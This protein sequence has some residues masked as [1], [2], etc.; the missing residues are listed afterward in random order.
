MSYILNA[1]K[2]AERDR[3]RED[4]QDLND[5]ASAHWDPYQSPPKA[6]GPGRW[7]VAGV[8]LLLG[9]VV[10]GFLSGQ[11][12]QYVP[13]N[14]TT[15]ATP[16]ISEFVPEV[17]ET[18]VTQNEIRA[19]GTA[20]ISEAH[21][22]APTAETIPDFRVA[23]HMFINEGSSSNRLFIGDR[24]LREGDA[25]DKT[26]TLVSINPDNFVIRDGNRT[27]ILSYR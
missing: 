27:E 12:M 1:L 3:L 23:G 15:I 20:N 16:L 5:F 26:W 10:G 4:P 8:L 25:L 6:T 24:G 14:Q 18:P 19:E 21:T 7:L 11:W 17:I 9:L 2:K 22:S 13:A